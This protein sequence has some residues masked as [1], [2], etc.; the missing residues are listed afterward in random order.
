MSSNGD[1]NSIL[2]GTIGMFATVH[3][4]LDDRHQYV[5]LSTY[6]CNKVRHQA[7]NAG[8]CTVDGITR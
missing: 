5:A 6:M 7:A 2:D 4:L 1:A 8:E 3:G